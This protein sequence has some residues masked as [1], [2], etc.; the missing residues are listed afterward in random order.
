MVHQA[1]VWNEVDTVQHWYKDECSLAD[2]DYIRATKLAL[3]WK[4]LD[5]I[6]ES[7]KVGLDSNLSKSVRK[8]YLLDDGNLTNTEEKAKMCR[9]SWKK[10]YPNCKEVHIIDKNNFDDISLINFLRRNS[11][12]F[13]LTKPDEF[14][15]KLNNFSIFYSDDNQL[16]KAVWKELRVPVLQNLEFYESGIFILNCKKSPELKNFSYWISGTYNLSMPK[17]QFV[18]KYPKRYLQSFKDSQH[19]IVIKMEQLSKI[20]IK[21]FKKEP[22]YGQMLMKSE[23]SWEHFIKYDSSDGNIE[24]LSPNLPLFRK[25]CPKF[26][27]K[28]ILYLGNG[29][30]TRN[31]KENNEVENLH[32]TE[33]QVKFNMRNTIK[34]NPLMKLNETDRDK[35]LES[36]CTLKKNSSKFEFKVH[37]GKVN[38]RFPP[39]QSNE[40]ES[41][42]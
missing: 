18:Q 31:I 38:N 27:L 9:D 41:F 11:E 7:I 13:P 1:E 42:C 26:N 37:K 16:Q 29:K 15:F 35:Y 17:M 14:D 4:D 32:P 30:I 2:V 20:R 8:I 19:C 21:S 6:T 36:L 34:H 39:H 22:F 23:S 10:Y 28:V 25:K 12:N 40:K 33:A 5:T 3:S 24:A